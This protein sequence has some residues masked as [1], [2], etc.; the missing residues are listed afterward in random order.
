MT[1]WEEGA[2]TEWGQ[3]PVPEANAE[4]WPKGRRALIT[5]SGEKKLGFRKMKIDTE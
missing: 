5:S 4:K 1:G 3:R 2:L